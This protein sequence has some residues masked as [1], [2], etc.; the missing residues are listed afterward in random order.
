[1]AVRYNETDWKH[2]I[3]EVLK[4]IQPDINDILSEYGVPLLDDLGRVIKN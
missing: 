1:M 3:N 4:E 2:R